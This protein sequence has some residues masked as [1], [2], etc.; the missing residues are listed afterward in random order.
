MNNETK[1]P[2]LTIPSEVGYFLAIIIMALSVAMCTAAD[3]GVSM[4]VAPAY[5]VSQKIGITFGQGEYVVQGIMF[6]L[7]CILMRKFKLS[8]FLSFVTGLIYGGVLDLWRSVIPVL[9]PEVTTFSELDLSVR[10]GLFVVGELMTTLSVAMFFK[11]Y[12][13]PQVYDFFV[14][15]ITAR[16]N[17]NRTKFKIGFDVTMLCLGIALTLLFFHGFVGIG[18]GTFLMCAVNGALIGFF[19]RTLDKVVTFQP[20]ATKLAAYLESATQADEATSAS[21]EK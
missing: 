12:L 19:D 9:N 16:Y 1:A 3:F 14:K 7:F 4:I 2:K 8:Y 15:G 21:V 20:A 10:I 11:V 5:I 13:Y 6:I 17:L 18:V